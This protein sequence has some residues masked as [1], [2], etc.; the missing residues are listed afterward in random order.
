M[1]GGDQDG[2][3]QLWGATGAIN[4]GQ[5]RADSPAPNLHL[6]EL[7]FTDYG[8]RQEELASLG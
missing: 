6:K 2:C 3:T 1:E 4:V 7:F 5:A 8:E